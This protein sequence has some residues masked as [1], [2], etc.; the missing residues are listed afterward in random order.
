MTPNITGNH[1]VSVEELTSIGT[2][3]SSCSSAG[4][5][6]TKAALDDFAV[7]LQ[8]NMG[9]MTGITSQQQHLIQNWKDGRGKELLDCNFLKNAI[10]AA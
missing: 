2:I 9:T 7:Y 4:G 6:T 8:E 3:S 5:S 1:L 10:Q